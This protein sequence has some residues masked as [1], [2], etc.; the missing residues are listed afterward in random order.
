VCKGSLLA[1]RNGKEVEL[2]HAPAIVGEA[3]IMASEYEAARTRPMT[4]RALA[5]CRLWMLT[6]H[7][8]DHVRALPLILLVKQWP[9]CPSRGTVMLGIDVPALA[10]VTLNTQVMNTQVM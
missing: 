8:L 9:T 3:A 4:L 2:F 7:D 5:C 1:L 10:H 6:L